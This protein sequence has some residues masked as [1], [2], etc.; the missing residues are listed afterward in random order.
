MLHPHVKF[1]QITPHL[2]PDQFSGRNTINAP[3]IFDRLVLEDE[4]TDEILLVSI[5]LG[6]KAPRYPL[7]S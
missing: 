6:A 1:L 7:S 2:Q 3:P 4:M 5:P